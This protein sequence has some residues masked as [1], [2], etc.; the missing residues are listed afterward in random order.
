MQPIDHRDDMLIAILFSF[1]LLKLLTDSATAMR[2]AV[3]IF[4]AV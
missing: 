3:N 4:I 1:L 2:N